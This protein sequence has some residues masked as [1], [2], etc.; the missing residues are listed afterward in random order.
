MPDTPPPP[1]NEEF[2]S[3]PTLFR[4]RQ[5]WVYAL[6]LPRFAKPSFCC[7]VLALG[8]PLV[9]SD[10]VRMTDLN[11]LLNLSGKSHFDSAIAI[12]NHGQVIAGGLVMN[13]I[14]EPSSYVLMPAGL[15]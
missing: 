13:A 8:S 3:R 1:D 7:V 9:V 5:V 6:E 4:L 12:N 2:L 10:G 11:A 15:G 14:P